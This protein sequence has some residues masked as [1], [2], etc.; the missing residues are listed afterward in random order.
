[1]LTHMTLAPIGVSNIFREHM[2]ANSYQCEFVVHT[3]YYFY[4]KGRLCES[5]ILDV[6]LDGVHGC[7]NPKGCLA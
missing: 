4:H 5:I 7:I 1:M 3:L 2:F 6:P